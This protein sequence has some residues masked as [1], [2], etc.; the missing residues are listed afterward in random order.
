DHADQLHVGEQA[1]GKGKIDRRPAESIHRSS[2]RRIDRIESDRSH[3]QAR[4]TDSF[5]LIAPART[6]RD[7]ITSSFFK[8][9]AGILL[10]SVAI[11]DSM[12]PAQSHPAS[13]A[14]RG[15]AKRRISFAF[16][17]LRATFAMTISPVTL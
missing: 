9:S 17:T 15:N 12:S 11:A 14:S 7:T 2:K 10:R 6:G 5:P 3:N 8:M 4:H 16:A 13:S 1:G